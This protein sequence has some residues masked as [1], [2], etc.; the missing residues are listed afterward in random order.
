MFFLSSSYSTRTMD[1]PK[2]LRTLDQAPLKKAL[3]PSS[4]AVFLQQSSEPLYII[5]AEIKQLNTHDIKDITKQTQIL[6]GKREV[7]V[8]W[9]LPPLSPDCIIMQRRTVSKGYEMNPATIVTVWAI[10]Q[11]TTKWVFWGSGS[12]PVKHTCF[13]HTK[14]DAVAQ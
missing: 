13:K 1:P 7:N 2:L 6:D 10:I 9:I 14:M 3:T 8:F 5:S 4:R 11:L 12:M